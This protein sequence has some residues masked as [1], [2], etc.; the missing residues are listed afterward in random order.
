MI[1]AHVKRWKGRAFALQGRSTRMTGL[2]GMSP[3]VG[4]G[5]QLTPYKKYEIQEG[6]R[7]KRRGGE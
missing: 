7:E 1:V 4:I 3:C 5:E 6:G 2:E